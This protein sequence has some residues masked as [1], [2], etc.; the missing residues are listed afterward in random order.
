MNIHNFNVQY[1]DQDCINR[2]IKSLQYI[3]IYNIGNSWKNTD[4]YVT[5]RVRNG[6]RLAATLQSAARMQEK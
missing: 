4:K 6:D 3:R 1:I 5:Q 2:K